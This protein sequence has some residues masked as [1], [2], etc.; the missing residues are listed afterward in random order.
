ML[1]SIVGFIL[2]T[3]GFIFAEK[4]RRNTDLLIDRFMTRSG[5]ALSLF[6]LPYI[7]RP[8]DARQAITE[9]PALQRLCLLELYFWSIALVLLSI[10][11][12]FQ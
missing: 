8:A 3:L 4:S 10:W 11:Q 9:S 6:A 7:G 1:I 12:L 2:A 5:Q